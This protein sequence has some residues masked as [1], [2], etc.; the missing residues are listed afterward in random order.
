MLNFLGIGSAFN[1]KLGNNSSFIKKN[2]SLLLI[3]CGGTTFERIQELNLLEGLKKINIIIT[4]TH[5]DHIGSLGE[6]IFY[7]HYILKI[8]P[9]IVFPDKEYLDKILAFLGVT[10]EMYSFSSASKVILQDEELGEININFI[11]ANHS[12]IMPAYSFV[13]DLNNQKIYYSGDNKEIKD[14]ILDDF[15]EEIIKKIYQDTSALSFKENPHMYIED[16][17]KVI[18]EELRSKVYCM[19]LDREVDIDK[20]KELG[21]NIAPLVMN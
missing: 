4:H 1:T 15:K 7:C 3:D 2:S 19:H 14:E 10:K 13:L 12:K 18:P 17:C 11:E 21:F 20:L 6:V 9:N 16:I 8:V 5:S